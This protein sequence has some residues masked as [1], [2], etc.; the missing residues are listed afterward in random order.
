MRHFRKLSLV[1]L[2]SVTA[3]FAACGD[4]TAIVR[5][6]PDGGAADGASDAL[7]D[8][9]P[10][11][12]SCGVAV[13][14]TYESPAFATN[15]TEELA[16]R[17]N[18]LAI[19]DKLRS[20]EGAGAAAV[21]AAELR[22]L[23]TAGAPSLRSVATAFAQSTVD[24]YLTQAGDA[25]GKTWT[26]ADAEADGGAL[27]GGKY[28]G[29]SLYSPIGVNLREATRKVLLNGAL[30]NYALSLATG[31]VTEA[32]VDRLLALFGASPK[33]TNSG[34]LDAGTD[35][36]QLIAEYA[37][38]RDNKASSTPGPY[39]KI[40]GALLVMK[41]AAAGGDKCRADLDS[42]LKIF[43]LEW[44]KTAYAT[45]I[46]YLNEAATNATAAPPKSEAALRGFGE[47][48]GFVQ[49]FR[50]IPQDRRKITD[51]QIDALVTRISGATPYQLVTRTSTLVVAF[52][53]A[54]QDIGAIYGMTQ[55]EIEDAK[56]AY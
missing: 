16:L 24:T 51:A 38:K 25:V 6:R 37:A 3:V 13:P 55:T 34:D 56:K 43:F 36:D 32:T 11:T 40:K 7:A 48:L 18:I 22:A 29:A 20:A 47:A 10:G 39:R 14:A 12:L 27:V 23:F 19:D 2:L 9:A 21:T 26:P 45:V 42:A 15:A 41:A 1:V 46:F 35:S 50:G 31:A 33:F 49:S 28:D 5:S 8:G 53:T 17:A 30:Y 52:N 44:E 4:D 54:F